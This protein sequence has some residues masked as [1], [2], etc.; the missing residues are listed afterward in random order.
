MVLASKEG[1]PFSAVAEAHPSMVVAKDAEEIKIPVCV[2]ASKD[3]NPADVKAFEEALT[4]KKHVETFGDQVH[5]W[6]GAR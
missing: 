3:E 5:G 6:M 1:T 2:L 4:G